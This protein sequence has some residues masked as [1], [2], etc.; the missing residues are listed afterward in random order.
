MTTL[1]SFI[2]TQWFLNNIMT[3]IQFPVITIERNFILIIISVIDSRSL[4][5]SG[6][7]LNNFF[8][9]FRIHRI[10][11]IKI[12]FKFK[13]TKYPCIR[14]SIFI[15]I[16]TD[17]KIIDKFFKPS[18]IIQ[19]CYN[20]IKAIICQRMN[21]CKENNIFKI[22]LID[23]LTIV[24]D[25]ISNFILCRIRETEMIME[26]TRTIKEVFIDI[27]GF[28][29]SYN[30]QPLIFQIYSIKHT[31]KI[32]LRVN[33][34][35]TFIRCIWS[36]HFIK[37][38]KEYYNI[39][40]DL[41]KEFRNIF[42]NDFICIERTINKNYWISI[43]Q[44]FIAK[45]FCTERFAHSFLSCHEN[46]KAFLLIFKQF[47]RFIYFILVITKNLLC[48][49][50]VVCILYK[51]HTIKLSIINLIHS[52]F[53]F[54]DVCNQIIIND[55]L[56]THFSDVHVLSPFHLALLK[57]SLQKTLYKSLISLALYPISILSV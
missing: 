25:I 50:E 2:R 8:K 43:F 36:K 30:K 19:F 39:L 26:T 38:I 53:Q 51:M 46:T 37:L 16:R 11:F 18:T 52:R 33:I 57:Y 21:I 41:S 45:I 10:L 12:Y 48:N 55:I 4:F 35:V 24:F 32:F 9:Y 44:A 42:R 56:V 14:I 3:S 13:N 7:I 17:I 15:C 20:C 22:I 34:I 23:I 47:V 5:S 54:R 6:K 28:I 40:F 31:E 49:R 29:R 27:R 1:I